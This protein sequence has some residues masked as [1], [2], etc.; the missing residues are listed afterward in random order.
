MNKILLEDLINTGILSVS[1][2]VAIYLVSFSKD[3]AFQGTAAQIPDGYKNFT[4]N[5]L[6]AE[7]DVM[8]IRVKIG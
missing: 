8:K 6:V 2:E 1:Q 3:I 4:V 7:G 5:G